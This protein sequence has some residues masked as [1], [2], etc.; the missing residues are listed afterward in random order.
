MNDFIQCVTKMREY[1]R[2]YFEAARKGMSSAAKQV[3]P[4]AKAYEA[5]VDAMLKEIKG[6]VNNTQVKMFE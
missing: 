5:K 6:E 3:L 4:H 1:Q 2:Q